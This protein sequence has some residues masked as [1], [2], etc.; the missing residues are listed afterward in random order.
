MEWL[1]LSLKY[2]FGGSGG[3]F[4]DLWGCDASRASMR[5]SDCG[6]TPAVTALPVTDIYCDNTMFLELF[7]VDTKATCLIFNKR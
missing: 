1:I 4:P 5:T 7:V 6:F 2:R 3:C